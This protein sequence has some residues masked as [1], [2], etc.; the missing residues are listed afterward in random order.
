MH[1]QAR[2]LGSHVVDG[3]QDHVKYSKRKR[4]RMMEGVGSSDG[5]MVVYDM[6]FDVTSTLL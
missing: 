5:C 6:N 2:P 4:M 1:V 3:S